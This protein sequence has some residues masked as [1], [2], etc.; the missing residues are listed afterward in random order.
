MTVSRPVVRLFLTT[1]VLLVL[2][3]PSAFAQPSGPM[4]VPPPGI[5]ATQQIDDLKDVS[6]DQKLDSQIPLD[7]VFTDETG[8]DVQLG[9][10]SVHSRAEFAVHR[11]AIGAQRLIDVRFQLAIH[12]DPL[13]RLIFA[14]L[15]VAFVTIV[16]VDQLSARA[17]VHALDDR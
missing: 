8:R 9:A 10:D 15:D 5:A 2:G 3:A 13:N 17:Q 1:L 4:S 14:S 16:F 12:D 11:F 6:I 7:L